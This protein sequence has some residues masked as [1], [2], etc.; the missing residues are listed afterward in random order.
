MRLFRLYYVLSNGN[1]NTL[2][3][4]LSAVRVWRLKLRERMSPDTSILR[5]LER[6]SGKWGVIY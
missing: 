4:G 1:H 2:Q 5:P 6:R 3:I